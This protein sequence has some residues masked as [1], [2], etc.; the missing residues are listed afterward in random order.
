MHYLVLKDTVWTQRDVTL[1][2]TFWSCTCR[3]HLLYY[4]WGAFF[5]LLLDLWS[6]FSLSEKTSPLPCSSRLPLSVEEPGPRRRAHVQLL[7]FLRPSVLVM[8]CSAA[9]SLTSAET[10]PWV[11]LLSPLI[12]TVLDRTMVY[13]STVKQ[14]LWPGCMNIATGQK[15]SGFWPSEFCRDTLNHQ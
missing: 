9:V 8:E 11:F 1:C 12:S 13:Y 10:L 15:T 4:F 2:D 3:D 5:S 7:L 6:W 14:G